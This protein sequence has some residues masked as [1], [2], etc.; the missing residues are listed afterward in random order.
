MFNKKTPCCL[1]PITREKLIYQLN[2]AIDLI[3]DKK[4]TKR[5]YIDK[6]YRILIYSKMFLILMFFVFPF[7]FKRKLKT[8]RKYNNFIDFI[9]NENTKKYPAIMKNLIYESNKMFEQ[10]RFY[11]QEL[12]EYRYIVEK[13]PLKSHIMLDMENWK[14]IMNFQKKNK[15]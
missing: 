5:L 10:I 12:L 11:E 8:L 14:Y 3:E 15:R 7:S 9:R 6:K 13:S 2:K 1:I 4:K